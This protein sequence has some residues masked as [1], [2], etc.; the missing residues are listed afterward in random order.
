[1]AA[2]NGGCFHLPSSSTGTTS[3]WDMNIRPVLPERPSSLATRFPRR[4]ADSSISDGMPSSAR[5]CW[6]TSHTAVSLPVGMTPLFTEGIRTSSCSKAMISSRLAPIWVSRP[7]RFGIGSP[8]GRCSARSTIPTGPGGHNP[9]SLAPAQEPR[10]SGV[11]ASPAGSIGTL[12]RR[13]TNKAAAPNARN[14]ATVWNP[15]R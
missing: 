15:S 3:V 7:A 13:A 2:L 10:S 14:S 9:P 8:F 4:G 5:R 12:G 1:M 6:T 11:A